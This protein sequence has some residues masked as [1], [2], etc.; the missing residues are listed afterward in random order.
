M[1]AIALIQRVAL[2][3]T[4]LFA[5]TFRAYITERPTHTKE[6]VITLRFSAIQANKTWD[7]NP[8]LKLDLVLR[9]THDLLRRSESS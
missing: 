6:P 2:E 9:H 3:F 1:A 7:G 8:F 5:A 4:V